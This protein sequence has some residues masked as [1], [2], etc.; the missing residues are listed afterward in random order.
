MSVARRGFGTMR[1]VITMGPREAA[2]RRPIP[3]LS[4]DPQESTGRAG[5]TRWRDLLSILFE[6][7]PAGAADETGLAGSATAFHL[8]SLLML[9]IGGPAMTL[10]RTN[11]TVARGALDHCMVT[12]YL[13]GGCTV[14]KG[15]STVAMRTGD[16]GFL[17]LGCPVTVET[18]A[19]QLLAL[20]IP[21]DGLAPLVKVPEA[22]H[23]LVLPADSA[24]GM[25]LNDHLRTLDAQLPALD[26]PAA[27]AVA[28]GIAGLIAACVGSAIDTRNP[29]DEP[30]G[31]LLD[32]IKEFIEM[33]LEAPELGTALICDSFGLSRSALYRL[34]EPLGGV[35]KHVRDRRLA[36]ALDDLVTPRRDRPRIVD[37]AY[38]WGF[39]SE[40][41][42][43]RAFRTN[44]GMSPGEARET[45][46]YVRWTSRKDAAAIERV[47][48]RWMRSLTPQASQ[49]G[50]I[51]RS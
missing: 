28:D 50:A 9:R 42:F 20:V 46:G 34:F 45:A 35:A 6:A 16:I 15:G 11:A 30:R 25:L 26:A 22:L 39:G 5:F 43:I 12:L 3:T 19:F 2:E 48:H 36:R 18:S 24:V 40:A 41:S 17:N 37:I 10:R 29:V 27:M 47:L 49:C 31:A 14:S 1:Q 21:R 44:Y 7:E 8:G 4:F 13:E 32:R 51:R 33:K 23:G 38:H